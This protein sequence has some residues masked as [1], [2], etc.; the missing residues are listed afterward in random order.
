MAVYPTRKVAQYGCGAGRGT[1]ND[2]D[3]ATGHKL[4]RTLVERLGKRQGDGT[5]DVHHMGRVV[6]YVYRHLA[7]RPNSDVTDTRRR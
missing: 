5:D 4:G 3:E 1:K 2:G 7:Q 6:S